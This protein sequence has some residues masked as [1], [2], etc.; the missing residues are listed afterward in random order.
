MS[1]FSEY[2]LP[3]LLLVGVNAAISGYTVL[4]SLTFKNGTVSPVVF[5]LLR[6][7]VACACFTSSL[8]L[9]QRHQPP[10]ERR[11][12]P[13]VEH[14]GLF[15]ALGLLGVFSQMLGALSIS[16]TSAL[17]YG[18]FSPAVPVITILVSFCV[19]IEVF[20]AREVASWVK[21]V[22]IFA[23]LG[24]AAAIVLLGSGGSHGSGGGGTPGGFAYLLAAT[25]AK[26]SY[27]V[28][29]KHMLSRFGYPSLM[30][31]T[32]AY[33]VGT[34]LI[35]L[36]ATTSATASAAWAIDGAAA[37]AILYSGLF[38]SFFAYGAMAY[39]NARVGPVTVMAFY[40]LQSVLTPVLSS[41]FLG[42][43]MQPADV[44]GGAA[45][46]AGLALCVW[47]KV[48]EGTAPANSLVGMDEDAA[49]AVTV[50]LSPRDVVALDEALGGEA[51]E[52]G[53]GGDGLG[54]AAGA[55]AAAAAATAAAT[56]A[57]PGAGG[58]LRRAKTLA[59]VVAPILHRSLSR[60]MVAGGAG[61]RSGEGDALLRWEAGPAAGAL[62]RSASVLSGVRRRAQT[63]GKDV[64]VGIV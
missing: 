5:A 53:G 11:L 29:Q 57:R 19:G 50:V 63:R 21:V 18:L 1:F 39:V 37:G 9:S 43:S 16:L 14:W 34:A 40:P 54:G 58:R 33:I 6:D 10:D 13:R 61:A 51:E 41:L 55:A 49:E 48:A 24:G 8:L 28:L 27:P 45:I 64:V 15:A 52:E 42:T 35:A 23:C 56:A 4:A 44:G 3:P 36:N 7:V 26:A 20:R 12:C 25:V 17:V 62:T 60:S 32:W 47:A 31:A 30:L 38:S 59:A 46:A 22:G 2:L